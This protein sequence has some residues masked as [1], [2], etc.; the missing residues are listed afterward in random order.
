[1]IRRIRRFFERRRRL[2]V[3]RDFG[4]VLQMLETSPAARKQVRRI[5]RV[6]GYES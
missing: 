2:H 5:L 4:L 1:M 6:N 3:A